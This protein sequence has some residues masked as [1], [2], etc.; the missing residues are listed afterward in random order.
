[1]K[2]HLLLVNQKVRALNLGALYS[3]SR[4]QDESTWVKSFSNSKKF[5]EAL[6][7]C[8]AVISTIDWQDYKNVS[9]TH[10]HGTHST[11]LLSFILLNS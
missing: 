8:K 3:K 5:N 2:L 9:M 1:M 4:G 7:K 11:C 10:P 6:W